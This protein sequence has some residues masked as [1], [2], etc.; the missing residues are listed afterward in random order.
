MTL[1]LRINPIACTGHG[2]CAEVAPELIEADEWGYPVMN[3]GPVPAGL[4]REARKAV[5]TCPAL[6]LKLQR[7]GN[8]SATEN[9]RRN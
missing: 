3:P 8:L 5:A 9:L 4:E 2:A 7:D 6:A 1:T